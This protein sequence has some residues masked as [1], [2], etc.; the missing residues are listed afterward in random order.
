[1][2]NSGYVAQSESLLYFAAHI[3]TIRGKRAE[4]RDEATR[5]M[6]PLARQK[7]AGAYQKVMPL[8]RISRPEDPTTSQI[9]PESSVD[10]GSESSIRFPAPVSPALSFK[11]LKDG[12]SKA[13]L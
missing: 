9:T 8:P 3:G 6:Y 2:D 5:F 13:I 4:R 1:M 10:Y 7:R 12:N 11:H